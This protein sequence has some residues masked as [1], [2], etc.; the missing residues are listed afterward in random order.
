VL[1]LGPEEL[2]ASL[3]GRPEKRSSTHGVVCL[4]QVEARFD[5]GR[6]VEHGRRDVGLEVGGRDGLLDAV[7]THA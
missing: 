2:P 4:S 7:D 1:A 3:A 6:D 5:R